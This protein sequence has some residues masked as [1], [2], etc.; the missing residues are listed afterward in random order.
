MKHNKGQVKGFWRCNPL[1]ISIIIIALI[2]EIYGI[3]LAAKGYTSEGF[4][5]QEKTVWERMEEQGWQELKTIL[6]PHISL[7]MKEIS[8]G[9]F[10]WNMEDNEV[11]RTYYAYY[12][13]I[14]EMEESA[15]NNASLGEDG[16]LNDDVSGEGT[17]GEN[18]DD[19]EN[20]SAENG[21]ATD[22]DGSGT[23]NAEG[24][25]TAIIDGKEKD[26]FEAWK[27]ET[28]QES[29]GLAGTD[30]PKDDIFDREVPLVASVEPVDEAY[31]A[32]AVLIGD[33]RLVGL[34]EYAGMA[35]AT[36][37][38]KTS[39]SSFTLLDSSV[40]TDP[41]VATVR[42]GLETHQFGKVY[43][44][45]GINEMGIGN[46]D[47]F[48]NGYRNMLNEIMEL[49]P[50]AII[51]IQGIMHVTGERSRTDATFNNESIN[52]RNEALRELADGEKIFYLD[53]NSVY[54]DENGNLRAELTGDQIHLYSTQYG[55]WKEFLYAN[56][57]VFHKPIGENNEG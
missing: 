14:S 52:E 56:G 16:I 31:F 51:I 55:P 34:S 20:G 18:G 7:A 22:S 57:I 38:A 4:F 43:L 47:Y 36:V 53:V 54:D 13:Y 33:S 25:E 5:P 19:L 48:I 9:I 46:T 39:M 10:P 21:V 26:N 2:L 37:Y 44:M 49:Q 41:T 35:P 30:N 15:G 50:N 40:E 45:V 12:A 24:D 28:N 11:T 23:G 17:A 6:T 3:I 32:D 27:D 29:Q 42:Q 1:L 8:V